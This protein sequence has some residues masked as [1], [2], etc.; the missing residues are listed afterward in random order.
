MISER[1]KSMANKFHFQSPSSTFTHKH[2]PSD[3]SKTEPKPPGKQK[4]STNRSL[5]RRSLRLVRTSLL[6]LQRV[7]KNLRSRSSPRYLTS[8]QIKAVTVC[9][10]NIFQARALLQ[11]V[12]VRPVKKTITKFGKIHAQ[13]LVLTPKLDAP[14]LG[15]SHTSSKV[16]SVEAL[17]I[18][19]TTIKKLKRS[20]R[21]LEKHIDSITKDLE[22]PRTK[23]VEQKTQELLDE[24]EESLPQPMDEQ[25]SEFLNDFFKTAGERGWKVDP[26]LKKSLS[27]PQTKIVRNFD[28]G[29]E[30]I[31][32]SARSK[33]NLLTTDVPIGLLQFPILLVQRRKLS[34]MAIREILK[35]DLGYEVHIVLGGYLV[36]TGAIL[37]GLH[38]SIVRIYDNDTLDDPHEFWNS[39]HKTLLFQKKKSVQKTEPKIKI[40]TSRFDKLVPFLKHENP[41]YGEIL[42]KARPTNPAVLL[43]THYY[44]PLFPQEAASLNHLVSIENWSPLFKEQPQT[45]PNF[46]A[47]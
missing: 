11:D 33:K 36:I 32:S 5:I 18:L 2:Y 35:M 44:S 3:P 12:S 6:S 42:S 25:S 19:G 23:S 1:L 10:N 8:K 4:L 24:C 22:K 13:L 17:P 15:S 40:D 21:F 43:G 16:P 27:E 26:A 14:L 28:E 9:R 37:M 34:E 30:V 7:R 20:S 41:E 39:A 45:Q 46:G 31:S 47:E 29:M 38:R